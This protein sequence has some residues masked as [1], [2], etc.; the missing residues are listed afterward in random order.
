[1]SGGTIYTHALPHVIVALP[2]LLV[3]CCNVPEQPATAN[4]TS[5]AGLVLICGATAFVWPPPHSTKPPSPP[6]PPPPPPP[7]HVTRLWPNLQQDG[8]LRFPDEV[9]CPRDQL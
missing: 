9:A 5:S 7:L 1:M 3:Q 8:S 2:S 6:T 4:A